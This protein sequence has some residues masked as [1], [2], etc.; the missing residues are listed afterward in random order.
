[1]H[2]PGENQKKFVVMMKID[3]SQ[4]KPIWTYD[5]IL[6]NN[7]LKVFKEVFSGMFQPQ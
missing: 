6:K 2:S 3:Y 4:V 1:M 5:L 7:K